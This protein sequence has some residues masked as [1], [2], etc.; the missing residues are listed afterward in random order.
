MI[1]LV[2]GTVESLVPE[3]TDDGNCREAHS[4]TSGSATSELFVGL[5][6]LRS[7]TSGRLEQT[8]CLAVGRVR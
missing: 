7:V 8:G 5:C 3:A 2:E 1:V 6:L 4:T